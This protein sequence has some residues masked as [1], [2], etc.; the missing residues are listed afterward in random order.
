MTVTKVVNSSAPPAPKNFIQAERD[1][2][3]FNPEVM[4]Y[5][6]EGSQERSQETKAMIQQ[7]ERDPI[8]AARSSDYDM[9]KAEARENTI[10]KINRLSRYIESETFDEF[11]RRMSLISVFDPQ[12]HTRVGV[13]LG[14][15]IGCIRGNGTFAQMN[16]WVLE[17]ESAFIKNIYG[18]FAM[19]ELAHGSN[20]AG[21]ETTATYDEDNDQFIIN[22][23]HVGA[24]KWWIGGAAHSATHSSVYA[25]LI[26][27]GKD[28]GVKTFVVPLRDS[29]HELMPGVTVGDIGSKMGREG[30][31]NGWIQFSNVKIPRFFMLQKYAKVDS[32]GNVEQAALNQLS[33]S[34][35]LGGRVVMVK[36]AFRWSSRVITIATRYGV[37]RRQFQAAKAKESD[38]ESQLLDYPLHQRRLI[39]ILAM[40]YAF[41]NGANVLADYAKEANEILDSAVANDDKAGID[42][43]VA[44]AK[45]LFVA[46]GSLKSTCTW[47]TLN[48]IDQC[49]QACGGHGYSAYSGFGKAYNDFAVQCTWE[50]DNN[51]LGMSV[52]KQLVKNIKSVLEGGEKPEGI[53]EFLNNAPKYINN[54]DAILD[55]DALSDTS[56]LLQAIQVV[57]IRGSYQCLKALEAN[58][59]DWDYIGADLVTLSKLLAHFFLLKAFLDKID[60]MSSPDE[61]VLV[62]ILDKLAQLYSA[63]IVLEAFSGFFLSYSVISAD[64]MTTLT[65][66]RI[67]ELCS[68]IRPHVIPLTDAFQLSD[69]MINSSLGGYDGN[70]YEE[71]FKIVKD[72]NP[73]PGSF[74]APYTA[75][76]KAMLQRPSYD[77][78]TRQEFTDETA[79]SLDPEEDD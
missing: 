78:R 32:N 10:A 17:K 38:P 26:V 18:C 34:A 4:N 16:Y 57:L 76:I 7:M 25:R 30:I 64:A 1:A 35:L 49:R 27:K 75:S 48:N 54:K 28:Y 42:R 23:P 53:L 12:L 55:S 60:S 37:G 22:T 71:Y 59:E 51:I 43:G 24:T 63:T 45:S 9:T 2:A 47:L 31:D 69:M 68:Q 14:L 39:P 66:G 6:L 77:D 41:S 29:N 72:N 65:T 20:V 13:H 11:E 36:D 15:F 61:K 67:Q 70:F 74:H 73:A 56:K 3:V 62:E 19:T 79:E 58:G 5:F 44:L 46:S 33:Y 21:L 50:G 40:C 52:G 8:L